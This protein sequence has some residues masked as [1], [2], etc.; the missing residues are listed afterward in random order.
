MMLGVLTISDSVPLKQRE[1]KSGQYIIEKL[2]HFFHG[3]KYLV[4]TYDVEDIQGKVEL[5][6]KESDFIVTNGGTGIMPRDNTPEA[7]AGYL[8]KRI[9]PLEEAIKLAMVLK[10]GPLSALSRPVAG[11]KNGKYVIALPGRTADVAAALE[12]VVKPFFVNHL[13]ID[14]INVKGAVQEVLGQTHE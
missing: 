14:K 12:E 11:I 7:L 9:G 8:D 2:G 3:Y 4:G 13:F 1:D 5:L 10:N 6:L